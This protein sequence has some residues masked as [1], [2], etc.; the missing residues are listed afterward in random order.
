MVHPLNSISRNRWARE[1]RTLVSV[2]LD[3]V[4]LGKMFKYVVNRLHKL[5]AAEPELTS[6][7][8]FTIHDTKDAVGSSADFG[9]DLSRD[10]SVSVYNFSSGS[11]YGTEELANTSTPDSFS[12]LPLIPF[13]RR[14]ADGEEPP[15]VKSEAPPEQPAKPGE[16]QVAVAANFASVVE[17]ESVDVLLGVYTQ[18]AP[19]ESLAQL[20]RLLEPVQTLRVASLNVSANRFNASRYP[21][22]YMPRGE[23]MRAFFAPAGA[24]GKAQPLVFDAKFKARDSPDLLE[25]AEFALQKATRLDAADATAVSNIRAIVKAQRAA[26]DK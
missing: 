19:A 16:V 6:R 24:E 26:K 2:C 10:F 13:L 12:A 18:K 23:Q 8:A 7:F 11:M 15:H 22:R 9:A 17:D 3:I 1:K 4:K 14:I 5:L 21:F 20:A 25:L